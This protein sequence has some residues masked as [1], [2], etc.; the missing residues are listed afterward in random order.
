MK[1]ES[2]FFI[3]KDDIMKLYGRSESWGYRIMRAIRRKFNLAPRQEVTFEHLSEYSTIP[4]EQLRN[5]LRRDSSEQE[6]QNPRSAS[7]R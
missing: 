1:P 2:E 3:C 7:A 6:T 5:Y 4:V